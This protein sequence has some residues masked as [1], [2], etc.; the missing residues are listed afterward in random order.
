MKFYKSRD[1]AINK[2]AQ[3]EGLPHVSSITP[4]VVGTL[5]GEAR[6]LLPLPSACQSRKF[7]LRFVMK[8]LQVAYVV[9]IELLHIVSKMLFTRRVF[10]SEIW[11]TVIRHSLCS[12]NLPLSLSQQEPTVSLQA[13]LVI[14]YSLKMPLEITRKF[15][16]PP[17]SLAPLMIRF[18]AAVPMTALWLARR[19]SIIRVT[20]PPHVTRVACHTCLYIYQP[21]QQ[22]LWLKYWPATFVALQFAV[23]VALLGLNSVTEFLRVTS[24][25]W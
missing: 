24:I 13:T 21:E 3:K 23:F 12:G 20:S 10:W 19:R 18:L 4:F 2:A 1:W 11:R 17:V 22:E 6:S 14:R 16:A 5:S 25:I 9:M 8:S 7:Y 15:I